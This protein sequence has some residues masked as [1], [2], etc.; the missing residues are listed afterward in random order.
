MEQNR[1]SGTNLR[2]Y[3]QL[4]YNKGV[5]TTQWG[6]DSLFNECK[7]IFFKGLMEKNAV[8]IVSAGL[9]DI[10]DVHHHNLLPP[11]LE[12]LHFPLVFRLIW[13]T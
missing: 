12:I 6:K 9:E 8:R 4:I 1:D 13:V 2:I 11:F 3:G 10:T 7:G 5:K